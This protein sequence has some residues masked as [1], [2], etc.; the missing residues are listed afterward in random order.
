M[1]LIFIKQKNITVHF[2]IL[3]K[4]PLFLRNQHAIIKEGVFWNQNQFTSL[5]L[6]SLLCKCGK[7]LYFPQIFRIKIKSDGNIKLPQHCLEHLQTLRECYFLFSS[8]HLS[9][10]KVLHMIIHTGLQ[11]KFSHSLPSLQD[12]NI[13]NQQ[14]VKVTTC[15][16]LS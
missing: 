14:P 11:S 9:W 16:P 4:T 2:K 1:K 5:R 6:I 8:S 13:P 3:N 15:F 12:L 10:R 7:Q